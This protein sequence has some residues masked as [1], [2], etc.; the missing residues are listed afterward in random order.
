MASFLCSISR[1]FEYLEPVTSIQPRPGPYWTFEETFWKRFELFEFES[2]K[3]A[4]EKKIEKWTNARV[5][6]SRHLSSFCWCQTER[7]LSFEI[8]LHVIGFCTTLAVRAI[9][10]RGREAILPSYKFFVFT[11]FFVP[12]YDPEAL[13]C[14]FSIAS[15]LIFAITA[16]FWSARRDLQN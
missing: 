11:T 15:E 14:A 7:H 6:S 13:D 3:T 5:S 16:Y 4:K 9:V 1:T 12:E 2:M 10:A 8:R